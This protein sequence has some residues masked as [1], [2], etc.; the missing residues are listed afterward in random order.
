MEINV[1]DI[2]IYDD[3]GYRWHTEETRQPTW[4]QIE[5]SIRALNRFQR[6]SIHLRLYEETYETGYLSVLGGVGANSVSG[7]LDG[8][9]H[10]NYFDASKSTEEIDIWT[11]DQGYYPEE[12]YVCYDVDLVL[13]IAHHFAQ[14]GQFH[15]SVT[16]Q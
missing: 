12:Q 1:L 4:E 13:K 7:T 3:N 2:T 6:P 11:S 8:D 16:W 9:T 10:L 14:F 5:A 15:P